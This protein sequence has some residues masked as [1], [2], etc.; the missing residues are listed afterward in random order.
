MVVSSEPEAEVDGV[1]RSQRVGSQLRTVSVDVELLSCSE[2]PRRHQPE[3][4]RHRYET[5]GQQAE[6]QGGFEHA[7]LGM[8]SQL[9][10]RG[11]LVD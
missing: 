5:V 8:S 7:T 1:G 10:C 2:P 4:V 11:A 9:G 6:G 3:A